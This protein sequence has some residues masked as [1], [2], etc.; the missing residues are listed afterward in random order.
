MNTTTTTAEFPKAYY[1]AAG[2]VNDIKSSLN[3]SFGGYDTYF[4]TTDTAEAEDSIENLRR[5][6]NLRESQVEQARQAL[7]TYEAEVKANGPRK[8]NE[9]QVESYNRRRTEEQVA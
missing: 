3:T 2:A 6:I 7:A 5:L 1:D 4:F 8:Y 9:F